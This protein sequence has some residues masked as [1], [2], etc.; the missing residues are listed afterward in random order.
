[1]VRLGATRRALALLGTCCLLPACFLLGPASGFRE[2]Y[3][4][5]SFD[6]LFVVAEAVLDQDALIELAD[7][8]AGRIETAWSPPAPERG[9]RLLRRRRALVCLTQQPGAVELAIR[10]ATQIQRTEPPTSD[11][12]PARDDNATAA[13]LSQRIRMLL[14]TPR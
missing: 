6:D 14:G 2:L 13:R 7:R 5:Y 9:G 4:E 8:N 10:V 3:P 12:L 11:W 1:M